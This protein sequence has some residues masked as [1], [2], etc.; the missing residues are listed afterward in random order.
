MKTWQCF[1]KKD[2]EEDEEIAVICAENDCI[3]EL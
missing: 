1:G 2:L 3:T